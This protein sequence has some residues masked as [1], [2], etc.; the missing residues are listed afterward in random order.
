M[1]FAAD[2]KPNSVPAQFD[3]GVET[4]FEMPERRPSTLFPNRVDLPATVVSFC[5]IAA[6]SD[7]FELGNFR[8]RASSARSSYFAPNRADWVGDTSN[9]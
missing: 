1:T 5:P 7:A 3:R 8:D 2:V 6:T 4:T 9:G